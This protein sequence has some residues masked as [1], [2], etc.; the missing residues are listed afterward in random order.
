MLYV[1]NSEAETD[2]VKNNDEGTLH[3]VDP[4]ELGKYKIFKDVK[5]VLDEISKL[6]AWRV[7]TAKSVF[8]GE[9]ELVSF[10][11]E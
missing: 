4:T 6:K 7:F 10:E 11:I 8:D 5:I 2:V 1:T 3:R 9:W